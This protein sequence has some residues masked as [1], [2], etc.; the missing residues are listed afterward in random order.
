[1]KNKNKL[2]LFIGGYRWSGSGAVCDWL[3]GHE[4][5]AEPEGSDSSYGEIRAVN[6]G[7]KYLVQTAAGMIRWGER[8]GRWA[9]CPDPKLQN[10]ILGSYLNS[11][12]GPL[13]PVYL[14]LDYLFTT[15]AKHFIIPSLSAY[16]P[17]LDSQLGRD[18]SSDKEYL[19]A[20]EQFAKSLKKNTFNSSTPPWEVKEVIHSASAVIAVL[21]ERIS[22]E[23]IIPIYN[24]AFSGLHPEHFNL[25]EPELFRR[26]IFILVRR[27][28]RDQF[29]DLVHFSGSTFSWSV[30]KF[31][32]QYAD[33]Q[34]RTTKYLQTRGEST[35]EFIT[36]LNFE[37]FVRNDKDLRS[38]LK[39]ELETFWE[40]KS[41]SPKGEWLA[42]NFKPEESIKNIG[43]YRNSGLKKPIERIEKELSKY[44]MDI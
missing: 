42:G 13:S 25:L 29:A 38:N 24:N 35:E 43:L 18:F 2:G 19:Q 9:I 30:D 40:D 32:K 20:I 36:L 11:Q 28:P 23:G 1:M 21:N 44:L 10:K 27:D 17:L 31:I 15:A 3:S 7:I 39:T 37:N 33:V 8:L 26:K 5:L 16:K 41:Y 12:R 22:R 34:N 14:I 4:G 6:Y